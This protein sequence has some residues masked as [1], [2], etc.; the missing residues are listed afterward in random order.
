[1]S[2]AADLRKEALKARAIY[3]EL[4]RQAR[5]QARLE[6]EARRPQE[7]VNGSV[8]RFEKYA[9]GRTYRYAAVNFVP[10]NGQDIRRWAITNTVSGVEG[11]Y[12]WTGLLNFIG[13]ANWESIVVAQE[14][15]PLISPE[16]APAVREKIGPYGRV[17]DTEPVEPYL[18]KAGSN[19][20]GSP[21]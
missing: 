16:A 10:S 18:G 12:T 1:M 13:E 21:F 8:I 11:R 19:P 2:S 4:E 9:S 14:W 20:F 3:L 5:L 6:E 7:P 17:T 15:V